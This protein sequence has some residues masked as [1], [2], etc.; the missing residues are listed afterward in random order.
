MMLP[1]VFRYF[2]S[3]SLEPFLQTGFFVILAVSLGLLMG[4][5]GQISLGHAAFFGIG[6][7]T[8]SILSTKY[9]IPV[10]LTIPSGV[11]MG[12]IMGFLIGYPVLKLKTHY[13]TLATLGVGIAL[14]EFFKSAEP[15]T[16]GEIGLFNLPDITIGNLKFSSPLAHY[17]VVWIFALI[18]VFLGDRLFK[19]STGK[20]L[21]AIHSDE[22]SAEAIGI[23]VFRNKVYI[24][25]LSSG[26]AAFAGSL[27]AHCSCGAIGPDEFGV[28]LSIKIIIMVIIGG[29]SS[30]YGATAGAIIISLL[31]EI[32]RR[33]GNLT[34]VDLVV[35][36]HIQDIVFGII[37]IIF[38]IF[39]PQGIVRKKEE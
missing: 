2:F 18:T 5:A 14:Q 37:L 28:T 27:F 29:M 15:I 9:N 6:A 22:Q 4:L 34:S 32:I 21:L 16:G 17:Y 8:S 39:I 13:L 26:L 20:K 1:T 38:V 33:L 11:M 12:V 24:F 7:Y 10:L 23:N 3:L 31:P 36:T 25:V 30:V 35:L 19:S